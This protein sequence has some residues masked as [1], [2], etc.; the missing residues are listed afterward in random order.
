MPFTAVSITIFVLFSTDGSAAAAAAAAPAPAIDDDDDDDDDG[1]G[2]PLRMKRVRSNPWMKSAMTSSL[3]TAGP[4]LPR[5]L[6]LPV[7]PPPVV[8]E[9]MAAAAVPTV[10]ARP[11]AALLRPAW[12]AAAGAGA[13]ALEARDGRPNT[14]ATTGK[15]REQNRKSDAQVK[16]WNV[17]W[18]ALVSP[19]EFIV[20]KS[21]P[22]DDAA[23]DVFATDD[24]K[25]RTWSP[26]GPDAPPNDEICSCSSTS[27]FRNPNNA[28][29]GA[30]VL[31]AS[32]ST[33]I[34]PPPSRGRAL[35]LP[36][37]LPPLP[38]SRS[39]IILFNIAS[40]TSQLFFPAF[41]ATSGTVGSA[42]RHRALKKKGTV[43]KHGSEMKGCA[44]R[45]SF[46]PRCEVR[47]NDRETR[48]NDIE[49]A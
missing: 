19:C 42:T 4:A 36:L 31:S 40:F 12:A 24:A 7:P 11:P 26:P 6:V 35:L 41:N 33:S 43:R 29:I 34:E 47:K 28:I 27:M 13:A 37:S 25:L 20:N 3:L 8:R 21:N 16:K 48:K 17:P 44:G 9:A 30:L 46:A 32:P 49:R 2:A 15:S 5:R 10:A 45:R 1:R 18:P 23:A 22:L 39:A 38:L 14:P